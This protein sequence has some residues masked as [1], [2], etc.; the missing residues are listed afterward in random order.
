MQSIVREYISRV[1][2]FIKHSMKIRSCAKSGLSC[3]SLYS[4]AQARETPKWALCIVNASE[5]WL[6]SVRILYDNLGN[7]PKVCFCI[8]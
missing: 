7:I 6:M 5:S 2:G 1:L 3:T 8:R 4:E